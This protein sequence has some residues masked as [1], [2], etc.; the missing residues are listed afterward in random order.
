M[1]ERGERVDAAVLACVDAQA[2]GEVTAVVNAE[3]VYSMSAR[4][5]ELGIA[6]VQLMD[7][8]ITKEQALAIRERDW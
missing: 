2:R 8:S 5:G 6:L 4:I 3:A 1:S 7:E